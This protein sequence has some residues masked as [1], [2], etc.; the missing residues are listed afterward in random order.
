MW[1]TIGS[2]VQFIYKLFD[3]IFC[4]T[5]PCFVTYTIVIQY[6]ILSPFFIENMKTLLWPDG[7]HKKNSFA[8]LIIHDCQKYYVTKLG[9]LYRVKFSNLKLNECVSKSKQMNES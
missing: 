4:N 9:T 7:S 6:N 8:K 2:V 3:Y 1:L 5:A